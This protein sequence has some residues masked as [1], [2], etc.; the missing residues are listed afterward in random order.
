MPRGWRDEYPRALAVFSVESVEEG[1]RLFEPL[2]ILM[3]DGR[4]R[5]TPGMGGW[6]P[7]DASTLDGVTDFMRAIY[8]KRAPERSR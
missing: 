8:E 4:R 5:W 7:E 1:R 2:C 3:Y 6:V